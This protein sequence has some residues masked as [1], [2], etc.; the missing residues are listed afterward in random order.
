MLKHVQQ[1]YIY[2]IHSSS[3]ITRNREM[4]LKKKLILV[5]ISDVDN[6]RVIYGKHLNGESH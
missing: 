6:L 1:Q 3:T 2:S 5:G 4:Y